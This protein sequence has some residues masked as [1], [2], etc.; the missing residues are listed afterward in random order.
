MTDILFDIPIWFP[1]SGPFRRPVIFWNANTPNR[2]LRINGASVILIAIACLP[3]A[4][5]SIP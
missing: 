5:S 2:T 4:T 3:S 1:R